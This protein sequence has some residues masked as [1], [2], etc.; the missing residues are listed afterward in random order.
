MND[1]L[2][3]TDDYNADDN[4]SSDFI[5]YNSYNRIDFNTDVIKKI[6][7]KRKK[8]VSENAFTKKEKE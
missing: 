5:D 2:T 4:D 3:I 8:K 7:E 1:K 6:I